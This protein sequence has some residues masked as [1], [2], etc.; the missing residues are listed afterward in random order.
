M[1]SFHQ[2]DVATRFYIRGSKIRSPRF[3]EQEAVIGSGTYAFFGEG[4]LNGHPL[5]VTGY[6][7][8]SS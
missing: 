5:R 1:S 2:G 6:G 3:D 7:G 4:C 8:Q